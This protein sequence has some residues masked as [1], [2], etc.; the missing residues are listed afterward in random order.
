MSDFCGNWLVYKAAVKG[1]PRDVTADETYQ[2]VI[3]PN[4]TGRA[5][6]E[7]KAFDF[8]WSPSADGRKLTVTKSDGSTFDIAHDSTDLIFYVSEGKA[9][10]LKKG[11]IPVDLGDPTHDGKVDANDA[12]FV[13]VQYAKLSTGGESL[14]TANEKYA[15]DVNNDGKVDAKDA[16]IVLEYYSYLSTGGKEQFDAYLEK[17][18][19]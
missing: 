1:I 5:V 14:L 16:S 12:S 4:K 9:L 17:N 19:K 11:E 7:S 10:Y 15:A 13:L 3:S 2:F 8:T 18:K 6:V